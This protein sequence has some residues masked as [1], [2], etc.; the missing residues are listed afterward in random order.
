MN[1]LTVDAG[2][3]ILYTSITLIKDSFLQFVFHFAED[4]TQLPSE[5]IVT[6]S[7]LFE[8]GKEQSIRPSVVPFP[9]LWDH[10]MPAFPCHIST[11]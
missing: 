5:L 4:L 8:P 6:Q 3:K 7:V 9:A 2:Q 10:L 11:R 1:E